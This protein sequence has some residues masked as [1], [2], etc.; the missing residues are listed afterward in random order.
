V[1]VLS[2]EAFDFHLADGWEAVEER[3]R[4]ALEAESE[5]ETNPLSVSGPWS[6]SIIWTPDSDTAE[7]CVLRAEQLREL[8]RAQLLAQL[9]AKAR[10]RE[11]R[12]VQPQIPVI[13]MPIEPMAPCAP[14]FS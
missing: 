10:L 12:A 2:L 7:A 8:V 11:S 6:R 14:R 5:I 9:L 4:A 1:A 3:F 13:D